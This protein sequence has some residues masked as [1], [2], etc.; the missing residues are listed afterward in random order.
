APELPAPVEGEPETERYRLFEA[1]AGLLIEISTTAPV[2]LVLDDLQW[3][4]RPTLLL[5]RHIA[6]APD[7]GR[8]LVLG[9]YRATEA[10]LSGFARALVELRRERLVTQIEVMGLSQVE[11]EELVRL[12]TGATPSPAFSRA[13]YEET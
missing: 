10:Q 1:V 4:D 9:A 7:Q 2:L 8:V 11:T 3:A 6:R 5:L 13:L 12:R